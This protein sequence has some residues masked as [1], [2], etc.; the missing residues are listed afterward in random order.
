M[1]RRAVK[2][3][4]RKDLN[5]LSQLITSSAR[6][7][8]DP[9]CGSGTT[10]LS[11]IEKK[12]S[13]ILSDLNPVCVFISSTI[14][15]K[16]TL[17]KDIINA[18][19]EKC[20]EVERDL[21][22]I[23]VNG[24]V[25]ILEYAVWLSVFECPK[26]RN[27]VNPL[28]NKTRSG[29]ALR[30]PRCGLTF[31]SV[32]S[33]H[34]EEIP[35]KIVARDSSQRRVVIDDK[36]VL[37]RYM[38]EEVSMIVNEWT[39]SGQFRYPGVG[40]EFWQQP[41]LVSDIQ[42]LFTKRNLRAV[43]QVYSEIERIWRDERAQGDILKL[44]FIASLASAT[45]MIPHSPTS[46]PSWKL[47]R[48]WV[49]P[50]REE[51]NFCSAFMRR[52]NILKQLKDILARKVSSYR[53]EFLFKRAYPNINDDLFIC[54]FRANALEALNALPDKRID[55]I[56]LDP[57]H[58]D[59]IQYFELT[60]LWQKWLEGKYKDGRFSDYSFWQQEM[61]INPKIGKSLEWYLG[62]L[63]VIMRCAF[64]KL[65]SRGA[66]VLIIHHREPRV[67]ELTLNEIS[68]QLNRRPSIHYFPLRFSSTSGLHGK[69]KY[70]CVARFSVRTR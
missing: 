23:N 14:L 5:L 12:R 18:M 33:P 38:E 6:L 54:T 20:E 7:V 41:H 2:F 53:M 68:S 45:K 51:R 42:E 31:Y 17:D 3:W 69:K 58:Y 27:T 67:M 37:K 62:K 55:L 21:Y 25:L 47:P 70:L 64:D 1:V 24:R 15:S 56:I 29:R 10:G 57:P 48:Y 46:G 19:F 39:P 65:S 28:N 35:L 8:M 30:C 66:L 50:L 63:T 16:A 11:A 26:C 36:R 60:Y 13:A 40:I 52:I 44:A 9:F 43:A 32:K 59:E 34:V 22:S 61:C 4:A 49:P